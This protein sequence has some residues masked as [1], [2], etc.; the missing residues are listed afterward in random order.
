MLSN[1]GGQLGSEGRLLDGVQISFDIGVGQVVQDIDKLRVFVEF[2]V[3]C[4]KHRA[5]G[6]IRPV[7]ARRLPEDTRPQ[8]PEIPLGR[9]GQGLAR[10]EDQEGATERGLLVLIKGRPKPFAFALAILG[11]QIALSDQ[12]EQELGFSDVLA[13]AVG[14]RAVRRQPS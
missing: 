12:D 10:H 11:I 2:A 14:N 5:H 13:Q 6:P 9:H 4:R 7:A 3:P 8:L 1:L